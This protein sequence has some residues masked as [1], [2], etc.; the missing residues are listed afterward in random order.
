VAR[1]SSR[2]GR[3]YGKA[4]ANAPLPETARDERKWHTELPGG[5]I[6]TDYGAPIPRHPSETQPIPVARASMEPATDDSLP[7][8]RGSETPA[9]VPVSAPQVS[10]K[11]HKEHRAITR[12]P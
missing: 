12:E 8:V 7:T 2:E 9:P 11:D 10:R 6:R 4:R 3:W 1:Y 5:L